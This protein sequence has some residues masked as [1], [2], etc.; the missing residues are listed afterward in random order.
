MGKTLDKGKLFWLG[1]SVEEGVTEA[2]E[3]DETGPVLPVLVTGFGSLSHD[4]MGCRSSRSSAQ[5]SEKI[6]VLRVCIVQEAFCVR[7]KERLNLVRNSES[8]SSKLP[9]P[10]RLKDLL[11]RSAILLFAPAMLKGAKGELFVAAWRRYKA[12][13]SRWATTEDLALLF[14]TQE[15]AL[16]LSHQVPE[17]VS[18]RS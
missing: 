13:R 3:G 10:P 5:T 14:L 2:K 18:S 11:A 17:W 9:L 15:V 12:R 4:P 16:V 1:E 7:G 6:F 8:V